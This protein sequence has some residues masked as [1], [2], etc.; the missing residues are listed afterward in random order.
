[1]YF[2]LSIYY[3]LKTAHVIGNHKN[4][5]KLDSSIKLYIY[6]SWNCTLFLIH[7]S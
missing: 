7:I 6:L 1:M 4:Q 3:V 2:S 5:G